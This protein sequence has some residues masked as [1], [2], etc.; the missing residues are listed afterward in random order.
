V[1]NNTSNVFASMNLSDVAKDETEAQQKS[2]ISLSASLTESDAKALHAIYDAYKEHMGSK[3]LSKKDWLLEPVKRVC[4]NPNLLLQATKEAESRQQ[5]PCMCS[6]EEDQS[7]A[8]RFKSLVEAN[9]RK[10][11][12]SLRDLWS[13]WVG[14]WQ[15][16]LD[17]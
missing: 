1:E 2:Y 13:M 12:D 4:E 16:E 17:V 5:I 7:V 8:R 6:S 10:Q 14:V 11:G 9:G 15:S 3:A